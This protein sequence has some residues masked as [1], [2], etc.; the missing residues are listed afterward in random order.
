MAENPPRTDADLL[1]LAYACALDA[2]G[3]L[4]RRHIEERLAKA[5][6]AVRQAFSDTVQ[7]MHEV[8]ARVAELDAQP[9]PPELESRILAALPVDERPVSPW[10]RRTRWL[11]PAA[12]AACLVIGGT[13]V[14]DRIGAP[15]PDVP[16]AEQVHRQ[17]DARTLSGPVTGGGKAVVE[18]SPQQR[19]A[20]LAF[21]GVSAPPSGRAYQVWLLPAGAESKPRS[22]GVLTELPSAAKPFVTAFEPGETLAVTVEPSG[23]SPGPTTTPITE[24]PLT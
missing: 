22:A 5:D 6:P 18:V 14:A 21:D 20:L 15:P 12:A 1:D 24:V 3:D 4:E 2:V 17:P 23:G 13:V 8:M 7:R 11:V 19:L 9:P 10:Q 16:G